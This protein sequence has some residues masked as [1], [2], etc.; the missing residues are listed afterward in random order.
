[1]SHGFIYLIP[2][3]EVVIVDLTQERKEETLEMLEEVREMIQMEKLPEPTSVRS[4]CTEGE[5]RNYCG[6]IF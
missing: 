3:E 1:V 2:Q 6:D 4:R 5:Y